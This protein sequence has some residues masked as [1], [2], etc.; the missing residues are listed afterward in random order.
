MTMHDEYSVAVTAS[1]S[2]HTASGTVPNLLPRRQESAP[3]RSL[4]R[5]QRA[6]GVTRARLGHDSR[7][8]SIA[9][10]RSIVMPADSCDC[11]GNRLASMRRCG[12]EEINQGE[13]CPTLQ[14][15]ITRT[16]K[17]SRTHLTRAYRSSLPNE[18]QDGSA[19]IP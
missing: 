15:D 11:R 10:L 7:L 14:P 12:Y 5:P 13:Y 6:G 16:L 3:V 17:A 1:T 9:R 19:E 8:A 18:T 2:D 4:Y